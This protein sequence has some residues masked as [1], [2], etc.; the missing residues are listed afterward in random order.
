MFD[1]RAVV[2]SSRGDFRS[3][4]DVF[5]FRISGGDGALSVFCGTKS[6]GDGGVPEANA[7]PLSGEVEREGMFI[8]GDGLRGLGGRR[9]RSGDKTRGGELGGVDKRFSVIGEE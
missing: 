2:L 7:I 8:G 6:D 3:R 9:S 5:L 4:G 1:D